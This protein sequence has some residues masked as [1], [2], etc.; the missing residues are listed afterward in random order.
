MGTSLD[1][2]VFSHS[3]AEGLAASDAVWKAVQEDEQRLSTWIP[4]SE[5]SRINH[6]IIGKIQPISRLLRRD[7]ENAFACEEKTDSAFSP[8]LGPLVQAWGLR[9]GGRI[10]TD[11]ERAQALS[12][13]LSGAF[14]LNAQGVVKNRAGARFEEGGF[15]K[16]VALD[17]AISA[18][19]GTDEAV[20]NFGGQVSILGAKPIPIEI[21]D[22]SHRDKALLSFEAGQGSISTSGNSVHGMKVQTPRGLIQI[23][24]LLDPR[25][26]K[27]APFDGSVTIVAQT[28]AEADC[29][30][31][32]FVLGVTQGLEWAR[33]H[34]VQALYISPSPVSGHWTASMSCDW[35]APLTALS[36]LVEIAPKESVC[37]ENF[38]KNLKRN[39]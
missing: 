2:R 19:S 20:L 5:L 11:S 26:G 32:V 22:P 38:T 17:D 35:K 36:A 37:S 31:K 9:R 14:T 10:P 6:G 34:H 29:L 30:S 4:A 24:H 1:V 3:R 39:S 33:L 23:G 7:L 25:T 8:T 13:S 28:G 27:P 21:A 15:G 18:L 16:G 12:Q